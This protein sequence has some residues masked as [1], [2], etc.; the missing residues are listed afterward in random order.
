[1]NPTDQNASKGDQADD[2]HARTE[3][4]AENDLAEYEMPSSRIGWR[5]GLVVVLAVSAVFVIV[6]VRKR[7]GWQIPWSDDLPACMAEARKQN[8]PVILLVHKRDCP[9]LKEIEKDVFGIEPIYRWARGGIP[10]RLVWEEHP[11]VVGKYHMTESPTLLVLS[12]QGETVFSWSGYGIT[13]Q[14]WKRFLGYAVGRVD[15]GTYRKEPG[16]SD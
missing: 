10:C 12:L 2:T 9:I 16:E 3:G 6:E 11:E 4:P 14:I 13:D 1:M 5:K 7:V 15:E 8:K